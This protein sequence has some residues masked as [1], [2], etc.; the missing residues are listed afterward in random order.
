MDLQIQNRKKNR[1]GP[2]GQSEKIAKVKNSTKSVELK[3]Y[4]QFDTAQ[5]N[6][7]N[8]QF[9]VHIDDVRTICNLET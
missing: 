5:F 8:V 1:L 7:R 2:I 6:S 3:K 4:F 9:T